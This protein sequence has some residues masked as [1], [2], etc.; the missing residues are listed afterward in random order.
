MKRHL[1]PRVPGKACAARAAAAVSPTA[2]G[3]ARTAKGPAGLPS[4]SAEA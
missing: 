2:G 1:V 3:A 4:A